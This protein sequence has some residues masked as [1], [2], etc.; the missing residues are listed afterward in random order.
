MIDTGLPQLKGRLVAKFS[1]SQNKTASKLPWVL[2][3]SAVLVAVVFYAIR[4]LLFEP[5]LLNTSQRQARRELR[6]PTQPEYP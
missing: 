3:C 6:P 5:S 1:M 2:I 4:R